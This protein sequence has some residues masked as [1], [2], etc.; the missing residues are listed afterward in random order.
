MKY[1]DFIKDG[2]EVHF[3]TP[4]IDYNSILTL[5]IGDNILYEVILKPSSSKTYDMWVGHPFI[6][7]YSHIEPKFILDY[8]GNK[9]N[10]VNGKDLFYLHPAKCGGTSVE[11]AGYEHGVRWGARCLPEFNHHLSYSDLIES[12]PDYLEG[13]TLFTTVRDPYKRMV[14]F[15]YCP[16]LHL[17][18]NKGIVSTVDEFNERIKHIVLN[19]DICIPCYDYVYHKGKKVVP[20]VLKLENL[21]DEF[22]QLMFEYN[23][24]IRMDKHTNKGSTFID[25]DKFGVED[26]SKENIKLINDIF[27]NDFLYFN[28]E[29]IK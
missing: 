29:M 28:Y 10:D 11:V 12:V 20:H 4:I 3:T 14:S 17:N 8:F 26:I 23:S 19:C 16:Y 7:E 1:Y 15:V 13:K 18:L 21:T 5:I 6:G 2:S 24:D 22:N 27:A 25:V 9:G